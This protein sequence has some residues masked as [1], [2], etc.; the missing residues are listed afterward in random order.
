MT[1]SGSM[2]RTNPRVDGVRGMHDILPPE[3]A[4]QR[5][6]EA[7]L[8]DVFAHAGYQQIETPLIER[9]DLYVRKLGEELVGKV[10][11][12]S[13]NGRDLALRPEWTA[14]VLRA[15]SARM[16]DQPLPV[17][18]CYSGPV[19]RNERPQRATQRQFT[20]TGVELIGGPAPRADAECL[21]LACAGLR[22]VGVER[23]RAR[24]GHIGL[25]RSVLTQL[26]LTERTQGVLVWSLE[27]LRNEGVVAV[28][29]LL[30]E[31]QHTDAL[32][33]DPA[34]LDGLNDEQA[35]ALIRHSLEAIG[36]NLQFGTRP[37]E[38]I[39]GRLVRK[40]RRADT[41][42]PLDRALEVLGQLAVLQGEPAVVLPQAAELL[43]R[44]DLPTDAL[45]ELETLMA[46]TQAH[47]VAPDTLLIDFGLGRG[48][49][50]YTGMIFEI[51]T[52][53]GLQVC[54][55]GRYDDLVAAFG[56]RTT[57]AV[58]FAYGLERVVLAG[59]IAP[60]AT[61][62]EVLVVATDDATYPYALSVAAQLR[63]QG[64]IATMDVRGRTVAANT[65]DAARRT[66]RCVVVGPEEAAA[67]VVVWRDGGTEQRLPL[68][69]LPTAERSQQ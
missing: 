50:Y 69:A 20:Q 45:S 25:L 9:R 24:V 33:F 34:L 2:V 55:G 1:E 22:A 56:G 10:Y 13:F 15:Y 28:R 16:Q 65:R 32:P 4:V 54:G 17:R 36:V 12:F 43:R 31:E 53:D 35:E 46:L 29:A 26:G 48:L 60:P 62:P 40:L 39:V 66:I 18:L 47:G 59:T 7:R 21:A 42:E 64:Y 6:T 27:R 8:L 41:A 57:P 63:Q 19:F 37:P 52:E 51:D 38:A 49:H 58:G 11:E 30:E 44:Y 5:A 23:F 3:Y 68:S 67:G 14:S 61:P